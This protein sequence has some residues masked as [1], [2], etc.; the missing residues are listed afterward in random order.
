MGNATA[1]ALAKE[2]KRLEKELTKEEKDKIYEKFNELATKTGKKNRIDAETF[3]TYYNIGDDYLQ[4]RMFDC[5][6]AKNTG[7]V[8]KKEFLC[9]I[10]ILVGIVYIQYFNSLPFNCSGVYDNI[11][12]HLYA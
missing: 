8:D 11:R 10:R 2:A 1:R 9:H 12:Q 5:F 4:D 7:Y 3:K 6:D